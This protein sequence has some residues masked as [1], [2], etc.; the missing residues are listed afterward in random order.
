M[1]TRSDNRLPRRNSI[2]MTSQAHGLHPL[3]WFATVLLFVGVAVTAAQPHDEVV[4]IPLPGSSPKLDASFGVRPL[5]FEPNVGQADSEVKCLARGPGY[6]LFLAGT[7]AVMVLNSRTARDSRPG[8]PP[9]GFGVR[10][11]SAALWDGSTFGADR[12]TLADSNPPQ[13]GAAAPHSRTLSRGS[14]ALVSVAA[15]ADS[16]GPGV[17]RMRLVDANNSPPVQGEVELT[18]KVNY[19]IGNDPN[20]WRTNIPTFAK[21]QYRDVYPGTDLVY[22]GN[23]EGRLE[24]DFVLAPGADPDLIALEFEGADRIELDG[25][26]DLVAWVGGRPVRWQKPV[27]YQEFEGQRHEVAGAYRL[28]KTFVSYHAKAQFGFEL[29]AYDRSQSLVIDPV[30]VHSTYLGGGGKENKYGESGIAVDGE[31]NAYVTGS[32]AS[33]DF[34][35]K[36]AISSTFAGRADDAFVSKFSPVGELLFSTYLGGSLGDGGFGTS[37]EGEDRGICVAIDPNGVCYVAGST[38]STNFPLLNPLQAAH[39]GRYDTFITAL[40]PDGSELLFSSYLGGERNDEPEGVAV[41]R[42][43]D[44]YMVGYT[45]STNFPTQNALQS[46]ISDTINGI[47][48]G[49]GYITKLEAGGKRLLYSTYYGTFAGNDYVQDVVVDEND[50]AIFAGTAAYESG[51]DLFYAKIKPD[52]S[53]LLYA[54]SFGGSSFELDARIALSRNGRFVLAGSTA[55]PDLPALNAPHDLSFSDGFVAQFNDGDGSFISAVYLGG[56]CHEYPSSVAVD[57]AG[58]IYV[59]GHTCSTD[60]PTQ[61]AL[62]AILSGTGNGFLTKFRSDDLSIAFSTYIGGMGLDTPG[63]MAIDSSGSILIAGSTTSTSGFPLANPFQPSLGGDQDAFVTKINLSEVLKISRIGQKVSLSWP[64]SATNYV[65][66]ATTSLPPVS[67]ATVTN[68]PAVT[69]TNRSVQLPLTGP[70]QFFRLRQP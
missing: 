62:Q 12:V 26:G 41:N 47:Q 67:W 29:A 52:G 64:V 7:E 5:A 4:K 63:K 30:L 32:T 34:P 1:K 17:L 33:L 70:A 31:G 45:S 2:H 48:Y 44:L 57:H 9:P 28:N 46:M 27:V 18:G 39:G 58:D 8:V 13:S 22:Y 15:S 16:R 42:S 10:Q 20:R 14:D 21:V 60:F 6:Q 69:A 51:V 23:Q 36:A 53:E 3:P 43:G 66:E 68:T 40:N 25:T 59:V 61:D 50:N 65:L 54:S 55:S 24:Y 56:S 11:P 19:F 49:D 38:L 35:T 37:Y